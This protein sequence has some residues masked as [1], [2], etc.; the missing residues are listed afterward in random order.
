LIQQTL[1]TCSIGITLCQTLEEAVSAASL[2]ARE[3]DIVLLSPACASLDMFDNYIHRANVFK[4]SI[5]EVGLQFGE[6]IT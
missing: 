4:E 5:K 6:I 3:G 1:S 2:N